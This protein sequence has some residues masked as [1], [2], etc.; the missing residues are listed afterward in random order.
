MSMRFSRE[1]W[2]DE[3]RN[4][5]DLNIYLSLEEAGVLIITDNNIF[6]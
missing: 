1:G 5:I 4:V 2:T 6:L 3:E